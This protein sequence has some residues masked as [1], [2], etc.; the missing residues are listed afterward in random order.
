[1]RTED[2]HPLGVGGFALGAVGVIGIG[3]A[4]GPAGDGVLQV[5]EYLDVDII[6]RVI[7]GDQFAQSIVIIVLIGKFENR[8]TRLLTKPHDSTADE[9]I[10]PLT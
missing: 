9:V 5:I 4:A 10:V 8:F 3:F 6:G 1:M 2:E 7:Q